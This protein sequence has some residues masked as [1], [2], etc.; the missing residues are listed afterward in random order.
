[1]SV[2]RCRQRVSMKTSVSMN[3]QPS[4]SASWRPTVLLPEPMKP[5]RKIALYMLYRWVVLSLGR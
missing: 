3:C 2:M 5:R 4:S 1:M